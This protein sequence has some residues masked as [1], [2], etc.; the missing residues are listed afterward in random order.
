MPMAGARVVDPIVDSIDRTGV[1]IMSITKQTIGALAVTSLA[2]L[3]LTTAPA[4]AGGD[5]DQ[6]DDGRSFSARLSGAQEV[7][8]PVDTDARGRAK[9]HADADETEIRYRLRVRR[10]DDLLGAAGAHIH[11]APVGQNGPVVAFLAGVLPGGVP[12][13]EV[14]ATLTAANIL[15]PACGATIAELLDAMEAGN[16]YVNVHSST[17]PAGEVRGQIG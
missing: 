5:D 13:F 11:C 9:F 2:A 17:W 8:V 1:H 4:V 10:G 16:A 6:G 15:N 7:P 3:A 12:E 14:R